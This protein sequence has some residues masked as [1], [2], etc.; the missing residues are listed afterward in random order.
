MSVFLMKMW[1]PE[2]GPWI[3]LFAMLSQELE[4]YLELV[5]TPYIFV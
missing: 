5:D 3:L 1:L 4:S 2:D